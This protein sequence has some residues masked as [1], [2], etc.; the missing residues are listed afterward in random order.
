MGLISWIKTKYYNYKLS[1]ADKSVANKDFARA[2]LIYESLLGKQPLADAHLAKMLA[3]N[4][5][6]VSDKLDVLRRLLELRKTVSLESNVDFS[7]TLNKHVS[8]IESLASSCFSTGNY[9][10][11][12]DLIVSICNFRD[13]KQY[14]DNVNK[15]KAYYS[16]VIANDEP[17][18][19]AGLFKDA[20]KYL[21]SLSYTP[22]SEI[23]EL[24]KILEK[25][26]R[27]ARSIK[28]LI[29]LQ[30]IENWVKD[31]IFDYVVNV[32]SNND[33]ELKD[34]KHLNDFCIDK[35]ICQEAASDLYKRSLKKAQTQDYTT[36]VL[37]DRFASDFL[38]KN[39][40]FN[41]D[42][43]LHILEGQSGRA[44]ASEIKKLMALAQSLK[45]TPEQLSEL[46]RR[47]NEIAVAANPNNAIAICRLFIGTPSFDNLYIEKAL[48]LV[49]AGGIIKIPELRR[50][51][52]NQTDELSLPNTMAPFVA[53]FPTLEQE[54]VY[55]AIIAIKQTNSTDLLDKYWNV[56]SDS[57]FIESLIN[58]SFSGW[59]SFANHIAANHNLYLNTKSFI[60]VFCDSIRD[61]DDLD[62]IL[63]LSEKI[64]KAG[65]DVGDFY[66]TIILKYSK[67]HSNVEMSLDLVNRGISN[68]K[69]DKLERLPLEKKRLISLL[70]KAEKFERAEAEIESILAVDD[71]AATLLAELYY[72]RAETSKDADKKT[73]WLYKVLD[74]NEGYSLYERFT[75]CLH[76]ALTTLCDIAK[77]FCSS[78]EKEKAFG[79]SQRISSY[80][81]HWIPLYVSLREVVKA[82][83]STLNKKIKY[84]AET[85][86]TIVSI[87]RSCKDY[88]SDIFK[89]LWNEYSSLII[90]KSQSQPHDKSIKA[91][92]SLKESIL[93]YAP[94][95]FVSENE[96]EITRRIVKL[97][98]EL[99]NEYE[100]D[101]SFEEAIKLYEDIAADKI[102]SYIY[103][104]LLRS[105]I[106]CVKSNAV[107]VAT[108]G[109]IYEAL[110]L[111][112][113][114][115]L[116]EDLA[117][118]FVCYLL[119][120]T[121]PADA[122][123][124]L[125]EFFPEEKTLLEICRNIYIKEAEERLSQFNQLIKK[126]NDGKMTA[127]EAVDFIT[128][129]RDY[130]KQIGGT[131][132]DLSKEFAKFAPVV[133]AYILSKMFEEGAYKDILNK[134][135]QE[136][137]NYIEDD[138]DFR[139]IAIASLGLIESDIQDEP[140]LKRAIATCLSA[141]YTDRLFVKSLDY[142][143][144]DDKY[145]FT[146]NGS[147]GQTNFESY[148]E[149]PENINFDSPIENVNIAIRDVQ[150]SLIN[151]LESSVRKYHPELE[152]FYNNEK[153]ALDKII[154]LR[155]DKSYILASPQLC[156]TLA[157][158]R[159][160]IENALEYELEQGYD[161]R[162]DVIALGC[163]YG[164]SGPKYD[165]YSK[166]YNALL[167]CK[168]ALFP[169]PS[170]TIPSVFTADKV[171]HIKKY[172]RLI[173]E[174]TSAVGTAMNTDIKDKMNFKTFLNK[175]E[176]ICKVIGD[177]TL[178]LTCSNYVN[179]EVVHLLNDDRMTL[180]DG[181]V[182]MVRI[183]NIAPSNFQVKQNLE[184]ILCN[185]AILVEDKGLVAD[186]NALTQAL[187]DT[188]NS[189]TGVVDDATI[190]A[191][192]NAIVEKV[193]NNIMQKNTALSEVY[194][195]YQKKPNHDRICDNLVTLCEICI[196]E[197]I[198]K[199]TY[200]SHN[201]KVTLD[202][203]Q[204]NM[205]RTFRAKAHKL[206]KTYNEI[207][208]SLDPTSQVH[209][210]LGFDLNDKGLALKEGLAYLKNLG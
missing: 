107:D 20:V 76:S 127:A 15:Y 35:K 67:S 119:E 200:G 189:F 50:V 130:K 175:Y 105:L 152:R 24:I 144:W 71:E 138:T 22:A 118:R 46:H 61:V 31:I 204:S 4:A 3:D 38:S 188:G 88:D 148:D 21:Y 91:L 163:T 56:Q 112:S 193:N 106:C 69:D 51:I 84:D 158:I 34:V 179:G 25:Q 86:K 80:W 131:L 149:L 32:I 184:G 156:R 39:N 166:G 134:L 154:E 103:R 111:H 141:I 171:S 6:S 36:A 85:L 150:N 18:Q 191:K 135:M 28:F 202:S 100:L 125:L 48:S 147:L 63:N 196:F 16:F 55:A 195:L 47:I 59:K 77:M 92:S 54:F 164:F 206:A 167:L 115:A 183:Y 72:V 83:D 203:L 74:V 14:S 70:I 194:K 208:N 75:S 79:I 160:S 114:Q 57:R 109:R 96:E 45:L 197:Y 40:A 64:L 126:L 82:P 110:K 43:C 178:S 97:K 33:S 102:Q 37:Y 123:K 145:Q 140:T 185:L 7:T 81:S 128:S 146:L 52:N 192:L 153:D 104:A 205:S 66:I 187:A 120:H 170:A 99:A 172:Q 90:K 94:A 168:S 23:K 49:K 8:S 98:W 121:R 182:Y 209:I 10:D 139:N 207:W 42:R 78:G 44:V 116:R 73:N 26:N 53:Y 93:A 12:V 181:V 162:E 65:K 174:L 161:N 108:E 41:F 19:A 186:R 9:K 155:L 159:M 95:A 113:Y 5:S 17:L 133:E 29:Q 13:G 11:A 68:I 62:I 180:R 1:Q 143:S 157:S 137:P 169:N 210:S 27:F 129:L 165:E 30:P 142:T 190:Q 101:L 124:L 199:G 117:Y 87:C 132:T 136:N 122:E 173:S 177:T 58:K 198:I 89:S 176:V 201:V 2:E 151:R 60:E